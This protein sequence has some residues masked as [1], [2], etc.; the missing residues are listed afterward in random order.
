MHVTTEI[1]VSYEFVL[2]A[3][4][5][6]YEDRVHKREQFATIHKIAGEGAD[7]RPS[8]GVGSLL[9]TGFLRDLARGLERQPEAILLPENVLAYTADLLIWW[10][11]SRRRPMFFSDGAEDRALLNGRIF[12]HPPLVWKV[13]RG[14]LSIRAVSHQRR[15]AED[16]ALMVAPY[17]N[18]EP[19]HGH[20]CIGSMPRPKKTDISTMLEWEEGFYNSRFTHPS[21][22]GKL[23]RHANG[24]MGLWTE[25]VENQ[26]FPRRY[27]TP[28]GET[29]RRFAEQ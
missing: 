7:G 27:L 28:S 5:M 16:T 18:T 3:A 12:P 25:L 10:T 29:L 4:V 11:P 17:W 15:P 13:R 22:M 6:I 24:F 20:V 9:T 2:T 8:L 21:G 19:S 23:T 1:G 26:D 14:E